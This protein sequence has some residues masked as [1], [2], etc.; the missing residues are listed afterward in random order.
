MSRR[1]LS[2]LLAAAGVGLAVYAL[3]R[4]AV[5]RSYGSQTNASDAVDDVALDPD[6]T[7]DE[8]LDA[9]VQY[10]FPASDPVAVESA[11]RR[12]RLIV[13]EATRTGGTP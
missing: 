13:R 3:S 7:P 4:K 1:G 6:A 10:T 8:L 11:W 2:T 12:K 5:R 9:G